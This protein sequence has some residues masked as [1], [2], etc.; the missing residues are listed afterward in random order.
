MA[1]DVQL[2]LK[3]V[4]IQVFS[5]EIC[6]VFKNIFF[7]EHLQF[8]LLVWFWNLQYGVICL[9]ILL[10]FQFKFRRA[11]R[12]RRVGEASPSRI[13]KSKKMPWF[14]KKG[15]NFVHSWVKSSIKN[16]V[17]RLSRRKSSNIFTCG[18]FFTFIEVP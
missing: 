7:T 4:P 15:P 11:T 13:W 9:L 5:C 12:E 1:L 3:E 14:W 10:S 8:L 17:L 2:Y 16:V 6:K 18:A